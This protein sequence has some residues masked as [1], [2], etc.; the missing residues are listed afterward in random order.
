M[1]NNALPL[2]VTAVESLAFRLNKECSGLS[3]NKHGDQIALLF[4]DPFCT[5]ECTCSRTHINKNDSAEVQQKVVV[6]V[7]PKVCVRKVNTF[8]LW[9][10]EQ[11]VMD[12]LS[13]LKMITCKLH[14]LKVELDFIPK[15]FEQCPADKVY[16]PFLRVKKLSVEEVCSNQHKLFCHLL[17]KIKKIHWPMN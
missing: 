14:A 1:A 10:N 8:G 15:V 4:Q 11:H 12:G 5:T 9:Q 17:V 3:R 7:K 6:T 2:T 16:S 13:K